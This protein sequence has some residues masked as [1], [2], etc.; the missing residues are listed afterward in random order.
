MKSR[1][2]NKHKFCYFFQLEIK[3]GCKIAIDHRFDLLVGPITKQQLLVQHSDLIINLSDMLKLISVDPF[4]CCLAKPIVLRVCGGT[5]LVWHEVH[6]VE[7]YILINF[8]VAL[9]AVDQFAPLKRRL[10]C[11]A[12]GDHCV[13]LAA[14]IRFGCRLV[15]IVTL[16]VFSCMSVWVTI[17]GFHDIKKLLK[18]LSETEGED[19]SDH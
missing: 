13:L 9:I 17:G 2:S 18:S 11:S 12:T 3:V 4:S 7:L 14:H 16:I 8:I 5:A 6:L 1:E 19:K 10:L 15:F